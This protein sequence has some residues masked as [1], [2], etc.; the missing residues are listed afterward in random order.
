MGTVT[1]LIV[2]FLLEN[3]QVNTFIDKLLIK[4]KEEYE[5]EKKWML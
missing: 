4:S 1:S 2:P 5:D 3:L